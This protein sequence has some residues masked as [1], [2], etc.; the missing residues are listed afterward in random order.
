M[1]QVPFVPMTNPYMVQQQ[2]TYMPVPQQPN[3]NAVKIDIHNPTVG[4]QGL[5][6]QYNPQYAQ[7]TM[8]YYSYPQSQVYNYPQAPVQQPYYPPVV[9][10]PCAQPTQTVAEAPKAVPAPAPAPAP[11]PVKVPVAP[12]PAVAP[13]IQQQI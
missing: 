3:Y 2:T 7:T 1:N 13:A 5:E 12:A 8:P 10:P 6:Q 11:E 4:T 9:C